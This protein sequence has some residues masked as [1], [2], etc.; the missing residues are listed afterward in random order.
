MYGACSPFLFHIHER[1]EA[2][3]VDHKKNDGNGDKMKHKLRQALLLFAVAGAA[4]LFLTH[5]KQA[6]SGAQRGIQICLNVLVPSLFPFMVLGVFVVRAG[7]SRLLGRIL[8]LP[9]KILFHLPGSAAA[10]VLMSMLGG[11]PVGARSIA[12][13]VKNGDISPRQANRMLCY[14]VN[15][16]PAFLITAVGAGFLRSPQ[17]G[18]LLLASHVSASVLL[19]VFCGILAHREPLEKK[20]NAAPRVQISQALV[21]STQDAAR[22]ML[23]MCCFVVLFAA[24]LDLARLFLPD[25]RT[26]ALFS[27]F[28]EVTGGCSDAAALGAP[29]WY[30]ALITGW[31]GLCVHLQILSCTQQWSAELP[32]FFLFRL[33]H[34]VLSAAVC[35]GLCQLWPQASPVFS[36]TGA[37]LYGA[38]SSTAAAG[39]ALV[40]LCG[41]FL[42]QLV[43]TRTGLK[44]L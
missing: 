33:L 15:A 25:A 30:F 36:N 2:S 38:F 10:A 26:A 20:A 17:A 14:C 6:S 9:S 31:G 5:S 41:L 37:S 7:L 19:G 42:Y 43:D 16:G 23:V 32:R 8:E 22:S 44:R 27:G 34:G 13:L 21:D 3:A 40:A 1:A 11:Y 18:L 4:L 12:A 28:L 39:G 24:V 29:L 35:F